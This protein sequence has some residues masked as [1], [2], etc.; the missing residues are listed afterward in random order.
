[1]R[2]PLRASSPPRRDPSK[3]ARGLGPDA[4]GHLCG[5]NLRHS[6]PG[7]GWMKVVAG[8]H[9]VFEVA[10]RATVAPAVFHSARVVVAR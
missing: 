1:M 3:L 9:Q 7:C 5:S 4:H 8:T 6:C 2:D 10:G